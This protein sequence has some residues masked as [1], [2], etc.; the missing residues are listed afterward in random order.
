MARIEREKVLKWKEIC[1]SKF[2]EELGN[3]SDYPIL[4]QGRFR[5]YYNVIATFD[6]ETTSFYYNGVDSIPSLD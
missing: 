4:S 6:I 1:L 3:Y 5:R 2:K